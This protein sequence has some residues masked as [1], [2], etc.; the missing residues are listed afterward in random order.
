MKMLPASLT[1]T[2]ALLALV[3][4]GFVPA[5][6]AVSLFAA[7]AEAKQP[8]QGKTKGT[9]A[10]PR[11]RNKGKASAANQA[12][13]S[14]KQGARKASGQS[15]RPRT[16]ALA[17]RPPAR[18]AARRVARTGARHAANMEAEAIAVRAAI[19]MGLSDGQAN[20][21]RPA[22]ARPAAARP[23]EQRAR[24]KRAAT[25]ARQAAKARKMDERRLMG[26]NAKPRWRP[27][28]FGPD[29]PPKI[30]VD[31]GNRKLRM[32]GARL[33]SQLGYAP[34]PLPV[35][36]RAAPSPRRVT[37]APAPPA[38]QRASIASKQSRNASQASSTLTRVL[39]L[40]GGAPITAT[41]APR[42]KQGKKSRFYFNPFRGWF[43]GSKKT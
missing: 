38:K 8:R 10:K 32:T 5:P 37:K 40:G 1:A 31:P 34:R 23:T 42:P 29:N 30:S 4:S 11:A 3:V 12:A 17:S 24:P 21:A 22:A 7:A 20:A 39:P 28:A 36:P 43:G 26:V 16:T 15:A 35:P 27:G 14:R 13:K 2:S 41:Q 25:P 33:R 18:S 6:A 19:A 9:K